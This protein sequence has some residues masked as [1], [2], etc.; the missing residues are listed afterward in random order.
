MNSLAKLTQKVKALYDAKNPDREAWADWI[1]DNHVVIVAD[2]A[3]QLAGQKG[4]NAELA[5]A[6][7]LLHDIADVHMSRFDERHEQASLDL[8]RQVM[9]DVGYGEQDIATVVDDAIKLHSCHDG[10]R[11]ASK[12]GLV[13]ATADA[14]AHLQ[15]DFYIHALWSKTSSE[16]SLEDFKDWVLK[17]IER[18]LYQKISFDDVREQARPDYERLK[19]LFSR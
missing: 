8:A 12:E 18:D 19:V 14:L 1:Y 13:L 7:A 5:Q 15:T 11:P 16:V 2:Y 9:E 10:H 17:K 6:A 4:A 3:K